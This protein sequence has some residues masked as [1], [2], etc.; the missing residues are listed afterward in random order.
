[1]LTLPEAVITRFE[2]GTPTDIGRWARR[3][4]EVRTMDDIFVDEEAGEQGSRP[5]S[6]EVTES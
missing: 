6:T 4:L 1:M 3:I 2:A 5:S